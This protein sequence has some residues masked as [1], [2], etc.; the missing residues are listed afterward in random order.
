MQKVKEYFITVGDATSQWVNAVFFISMD[1][2]ESLS[3]RSFENQKDKFWGRMLKVI[4]WLLGEGHC[5]ESYRNDLAR[6]SNYMRN[7][8]KVKRNLDIK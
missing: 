3:G 8:G 4:D 2:N 5:E 7:H 6:A 1:A